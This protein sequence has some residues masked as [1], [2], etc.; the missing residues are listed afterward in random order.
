M[1]RYEAPSRVAGGYID[2]RLELS[3]TLAGSFHFPMEAT[4]M[5]KYVFAPLQGFLLEK[6]LITPVLGIDA[7]YVRSPSS[8]SGF[9]RASPQA[10]AGPLTMTWHPSLRAGPALYSM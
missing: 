6:V 2:S 9:L 10:L 4:L 7:Q 8:P 3:K 1:L 5:S